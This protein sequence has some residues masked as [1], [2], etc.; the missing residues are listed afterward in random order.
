MRLLSYKMFLLVFLCWIGI[1]A[2]G[3]DEDEIESRAVFEGGN[4]TISFHIEERGDPQVLVTHLRGS[5]REP[6]AQMI[7]HN[8]DCD[9]KCWRSGDSLTSDGQNITLI[10]M[11][12][13]YN[14][15]GLYKVLQLSNGHQEIK[16]YNIT[17]YQPPLRSIS[18]EQAASAVYSSSSVTAGVSAA[19]AGL[20]LLLIICAV[21]G[22]MYWKHRKAV[23]QEIHT[24]ASRWH[25][26]LSDHGSSL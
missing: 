2:A 14:Q 24:E 10:L 20:A 8:R 26:S 16:I 7:C 12:L 13:S 5:S 17:V 25:R 6:I 19:A 3:V 1:A 18:P 11:N 21:I 9:R 23:H 4:L 22:V 15:T